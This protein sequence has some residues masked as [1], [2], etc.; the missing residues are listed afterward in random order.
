MSLL[1]RVTERALRLAASG[2]IPGRWFNRT[3]PTHA[4]LTPAP[5]MFTLEI[6]SHCWK[7]SEFQL[8]QL[9]SLVNHPPTK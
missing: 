1:D 8:Y 6:V 4:S 5:E 3:L 7:Y 9:S 2:V